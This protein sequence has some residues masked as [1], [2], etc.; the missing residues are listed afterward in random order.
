MY[1]VPNAVAVSDDIARRVKIWERNPASNIQKY[2]VFG[3]NI[4][5]PGARCRLQTGDA[6]GWGRE[7]LGSLPPVLMF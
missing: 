5:L 6:V 3:F 1:S 4:C 7:A 2:F